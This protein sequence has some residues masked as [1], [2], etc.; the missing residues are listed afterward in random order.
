MAVDQSSTPAPAEFNPTII[1][2]YPDYEPWRKI[3]LARELVAGSLA[4]LS[5]QGCGT[6]LDPS[7]E[8]DRMNC[9]QN[10]LLQVFGILVE[11][12]PPSKCLTTN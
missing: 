11:V 6:P 4:L 1:V 12:Q 8:I 5:S 9:A 7:D 10:L 2:D 3:A